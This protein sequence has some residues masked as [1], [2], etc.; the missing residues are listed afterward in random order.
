VSVGGE[1]LEPIELRL[2]G[3]AH[4]VHS[5][6]TVA[7]LVLQLGLN[8]AGVAVAINRS[9]VPRGEHRTCKFVKGDEVEIIHAVGGG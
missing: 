6:T 2:N 3:H 5:A 8:P 4:E 9:V 1:W 7:D